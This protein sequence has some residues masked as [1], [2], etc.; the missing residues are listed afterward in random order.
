MKNDAEERVSKFY[1][2]VGWETRGDVSEDASR[3]EDLRKCAAEYV[4]KCRL[5]V[6][7]HVDKG[8]ENILD[9]ASGPIQY[10]E[11]LQFSRNY[12]KRY[13]ID[14]S[15]SALEQAERKIG[16]HG[17][18]L[19]GSFF[20][21]KLED[22][23]F[24]CSMSL[25]TIYHIDKN[26]QEEAVRKL[27][28]VTKPGRNV[29]IVYNNPRTLIDLCKIPLISI[30]KAARSILGSRS[31]RNEEAELYFFSYPLKWWERFS[32]VAEVQIVPWRS[33][34]SEDQKRLIPDNALGRKIFELL[35][36]LEN[37]FPK[38][39]ANYFEYPMI[40]LTKRI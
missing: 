15:S 22:D 27:I 9:M 30:R 19:C 29:V 24:D 12:K 17:V 3:F 4:S 18:Y 28:R 20:D 32:D 8:G 37:T 26:R 5:R 33:F 38:F 10:Q 39:F 31:K 40:I 36:F 6:L 2:S 35:F 13:C 34:S 14:L 16:N 11:Y 7:K 1:N 21:L 23:F 25:H